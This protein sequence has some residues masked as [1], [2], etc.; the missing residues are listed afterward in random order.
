[1][2]YAGIEQ[3]L[4]YVYIYSRVRARGQAAGWAVRLQLSQNSPQIDSTT[5]NMVDT[6][7]FKFSTSTVSSGPLG[8]TE[9]IL[10][11]VVSLTM[12]TCR[13][14]RKNSV[15]KKGKKAGLQ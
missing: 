11:M 2:I 12:G 6:M 13:G 15:N 5:I 1:M 14:I 4:I 8:R 3:R 7:N 9:H 10:A